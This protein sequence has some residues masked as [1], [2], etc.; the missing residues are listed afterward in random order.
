MEWLV[1]GAA[2]VFV[3]IL[4]AVVTVIDPRS[5]NSSAVYMTTSC[6]LA[7]MAIIS[8]FT[9]FKIDFVPYRLCPVIFVFSAIFVTLGWLTI[10]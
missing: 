10:N 9:G 8:L 4:L 3:G 1:E 2:L 6:F 7:I 5:I